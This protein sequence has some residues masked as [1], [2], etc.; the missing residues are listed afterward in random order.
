MRFVET[1]RLYE[2]IIP[3]KQMMVYE[4]PRSA[5]TKIERLKIQSMQG[6]SVEGDKAF[7]SEVASVLNVIIS[8]IYHPHITNKREEVI[9]RIEQAQQIGEEA[10]RRILSDSRLWK[11]HGLKMIPEEVYHYQHIDELRIYENRF[12]GLLISML[13]KEL[14]RYSTFYLSRLPALKYMDVSLDDPSIGEIISD[15]DR[16][17]RKTQFL[18]NTHF[19]REVMKGKPLSRKIQPTNILVKD[20]LYCYCFRFYRKFV[21]YEDAAEAKYDLAMYY[22]VLVLKELRHRGFTPAHDPAEGTDDPKLVVENGEFK[23]IIGTT[24]DGDLH[25]TA[26]WK[27]YPKLPSEHL[28]IFKIDSDNRIT[29]EDVP[30]YSDFDTV[31]SVSIWDL[32]YAAKGKQGIVESDS[33]EKLIRAWLDTKINTAPVDRGIYEKYC[34]VCRSRDNEAVGAKQVCSACGSE[35]LFTESGGQ[36][37]I[38]FRKIRK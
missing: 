33:E 27:K 2:Y 8:I 14:S 24:E 18:M 22:T 31:E 26:I 38:W 37:L 21:R 4:S 11:Q 16:L 32:A 19:Y 13:D 3:T 9:I 29:A 30:N 36:D 1:A 20:R 28:L 23:L 25:L 17:R 6:F 15:I 5:Y 10:F 34:P 35:Y 12:I 7:L